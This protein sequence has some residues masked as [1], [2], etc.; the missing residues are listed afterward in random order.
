MNFNKTSNVKEFYTVK[1]HQM[2]SIYLECLNSNGPL[3]AFT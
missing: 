1:L 2:S 3:A